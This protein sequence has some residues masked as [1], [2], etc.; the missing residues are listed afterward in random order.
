MAAVAAHQITVL[1]AAEVEVA[2]AA[3]SLQ[4]VQAL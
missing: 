4:G 2:A 3:I 1:L